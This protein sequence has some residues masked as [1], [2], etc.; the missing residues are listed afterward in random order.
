MFSASGYSNTTNLPT[1]TIILVEKH[2]I[3]QELYRSLYPNNTNSHHHYNQSHS[4]NNTPIYSFS[5]PP[6]PQQPNTTTASQPPLNAASP[7]VNRSTN[8]IL[9]LLF[10]LPLTI[11]LNGSLNSSSSSISIRQL[12]DNSSVEVYSGTET[13]IITTCAICLDSIRDGTLIRTLNNC[14]HQFHLSCIDEWLAS[15]NVRCPLCRTDII[16]IR[17]TEPIVD[18]D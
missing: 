13:T 2:Y 18:V 5:I 9:D 12:N 3:P 15:N 6:T 14:S 10:T 17:P 16:T 7:R 1:Q 4:Y 8:D 11:P